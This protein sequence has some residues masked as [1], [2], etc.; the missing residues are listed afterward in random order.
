MRSR[1]FRREFTKQVRLGSNAVQYFVAGEDHL[2]K[3]HLLRAECEIQ[4]A[5]VCLGQSRHRVSN[6]V[7]DNCNTRLIKLQHDDLRFLTRLERYHLLPKFILSYIKPAHSDPPLISVKSQSA[8]SNSLPNAN[9]ILNSRRP[10]CAPTR[11]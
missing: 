8:D 2:F 6:R 1:H 10:Q 9:P 3:H 5:L 11:L 7:S 4:G